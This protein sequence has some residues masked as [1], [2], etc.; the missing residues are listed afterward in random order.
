MLYWN[1]V[2]VTFIR[3][4]KSL[5][6]SSLFILWVSFLSHGHV[7]T[8]SKA[9]FVHGLS[10]SYVSTTRCYESGA[11]PVSL[12]RPPSEPWHCRYPSLYS[13]L[14][15]ATS[16]YFLSSTCF[17]TPD[18]SRSICGLLNWGVWGRW[19]RGTRYR[20]QRWFRERLWLK[21]EAVFGD[22]ELERMMT[23]H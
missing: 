9:N 1:T 16:L 6:N 21:F 17:A 12:Y 19:R 7:N 14:S 8:W 18:R 10:V 3:T 4:I 20:K 22:W 5:M 15:V 23:W 11:R 13:P 2:K